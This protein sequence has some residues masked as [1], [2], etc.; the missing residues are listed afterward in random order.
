MSPKLAGC[1]ITALAHAQNLSRLQFSIPL[2][3]STRSTNR[4]PSNSQ[5]FMRP[6]SASRSSFRRGFDFRRAPVRPLKFPTLR[7]ADTRSPRYTS[8]P[9]SSD[10]RRPVARG[11]PNTCAVNP[12]TPARAASQAV[13][14]RRLQRQLARRLAEDSRSELVNDEVLAALRRLFAE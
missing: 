9:A 5:P 13:E 7:V 2:L 10:V 4:P 14:E 1:C 8:R 6:V 11:M 3:T 12:S